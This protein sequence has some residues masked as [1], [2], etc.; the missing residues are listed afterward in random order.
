[1]SNQSLK[2]KVIV[3]TGGSGGIGSAIVSKLSNNAANVIS[4]FCNHCPFEHSK[5]NVI[6]IRADLTKLEEWERLISFVQKQYG[7]IDVLINCSGYLEPGD[8]LLLQENE[9]NKMIEINFSSLIIGIHKT[10][11]IFK[12]Q[13]SGHIIT[14]GS[15]GGIVPMPYS[16]VYSATKYALRG[17]TFSLAEELKG[18]GIDV[19]GRTRRQPRPGHLRLGHEISWTA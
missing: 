16:S 15:L 5:E 14:I 3:V 7:K 2:N 9:I 10:L 12:E 11:K 8:F 19:S 17:F 4:V 18:T 13:N 6:C 1:M